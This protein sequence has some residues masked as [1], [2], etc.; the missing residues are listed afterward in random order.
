MTILYRYLM[1][2]IF[3]CTLPLMGA[4]DE[5]PNWDNPD[6]L[7]VNKQAPHATM[8]VFPSR[9]QASVMHPER[10]PWYQTLN[11]RWQFKWSK[12]PASTPDG[13][14]Q[15]GYQTNGWD[16][17]EVPSNWELEGFGTPIYSN[18]AYPFDI[19]ELRTPKEWNPVGSYRKWIKVPE[20]WD[21]RRTY[22]HFEGVQSAFHLWVN[23]EKVGYSQGSRTPAEFDITDHL[24]RGRNL[25]AVQVYRWSDGSYLE[26]QDFWRLSGIFRDVYLWSTDRMHVRDFEVTSTLGDN[27][28]HGVF[29][30]TGEVLADHSG[31]TASIEYALYDERDQLIL[32]RQ[33]EK[34]TAHEPVAFSF[35][36]EEIEGVTPWNSEQPYLYDLYIHLKDDQ[37]NT[38]EVIPQKVG[39][40]K[41][42][43]KNSRFWVNGRQV[44]LRGVNRHEHSAQQGH[45]VTREDMIR[46]IQLMKRHNINAV[47]T[48]HYP[49]RPLWYKLCD[50]HGLFVIDEGNIETHGFG[51]N[52]NNK[53]SHHPDWK[54][55]YLARVK[56]MVYRDRNHPSIV[57]WSLG[58][59]SGNGPNITQVYEWIKQADPSRPFHY[60]GSTHGDGPLNSDVYSKMYAT[61]GWSKK[62]MEEHSDVPYMLCEY[63]HAMGNSNGGLQEYWDLIYADNN[64]IGAFVWDWMDQGLRQDV[65]EEY[66]ASSGRDHFLAYGGWWEEAKGIH[67]DGNF[68]MNGLLAAD[69]T[70]HPG[71]VALKYHHQYV[72][73]EPVNLEEG[74][75]R[76]TNR[77]HFSSLDDKLSGRWKLKK[78]GETL[79]TGKLDDLHIQPGEDKMIALDLPQIEASE[80]VEYFLNF[81][82]TN[83]DNTFFAPAGYELAYEQFRMPASS[84]GKLKKLQTEAP[85]YRQE[86]NHVVVYSDDFSLRINKL[87]GQILSYYARGDKLLEQGPEADFWRAPTDNDIGARRNGQKGIPLLDIW[88]DAGEALMEEVSIDG[89]DHALNISMEG[90]L[91][92][93][94]SQLVMKYKVYGNGAVD[95]HIDYTPSDQEL[96]SFMPRFGTRMTLSPGYNRMI[97]YGPGPEPTYSDRNVAKVDIYGS[98]VA[99]EWVDYSKPQENGYKTEV[100]WVKMLNEKGQG[101]KFS[102][103]PLVGVGAAHYKREAIS[104]A[105][106]SFELTPSPQIYLNI[107]HKQMGVGGTN[108]W[109][110]NAYPTPEHRVQNKAMSFRYRIE[111]VK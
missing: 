87:T 20:D 104:Q 40:R 77:Y 61:P 8:M 81:S 90:A 65:P 28:E 15:N 72:A 38:L 64:F 92:N 110:E 18:V 29:Q 53:M 2:W 44:I 79:Q 99:D 73:V 45:Y 69:Q 109:S 46:D 98:T 107:D 9:E 67:H 75:F 111:P 91:I 59:E 100:R 103:D 82:F 50:Q 63:T 19:S 58:N 54:E 5:R 36:R 23:G 96:P 25:V 33:L 13:F 105:D 83:A 30:L 42:E 86:G 21:G 37:G 89:Q 106:Y 97:W 93:I 11:G 85:Q 4:A 27:Y 55:S 51:L 48:S 80:G 60:E 43:I 47:R 78:N 22:L 31:K 52:D 74:T 94:N 35:P 6:V 108:S 70:P 101:L 76:I 62:L 56:R 24:Q 10:S 57:M 95:V 84:F 17:I 12:N 49:N 102:G 71:L 34:Q 1:L 41:V 68:C 66:R 26:D 3:C 14:Q 39:F 7:Q 32:S 16:H 88:K